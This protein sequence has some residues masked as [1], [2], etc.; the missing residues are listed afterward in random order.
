MLFDPEALPVPDLGLR[1][2]NCGY[3]LAGLPRHQCP[4]CGR[5]FTLDEH[6]P[7]GDF[8]IV[9]FD[10]KE[11]LNTADVLELLRRYQIPYLEILRE[12]QATIGYSSA[13]LGAARI[14]VIREC[15]FD[16]IDLLRRKARNEPFPPPPAQSDDTADWACP[17]CGEEN[18]GNF[19]VCWNCGTPS[20]GQ[21]APGT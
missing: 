19:E 18:P 13:L 9:I 2:L 17:A 1:C 10:G 14:G 21:A 3:G 12:T 4:E 6:I 7:P 20:A 8:P 5:T 16:V 15:Y 11:L